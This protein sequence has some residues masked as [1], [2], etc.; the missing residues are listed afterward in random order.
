[1]TTAGC[2]KVTIT[3]TKE[4]QVQPTEPNLFLITTLSCL[5]FGIIYNQY[6]AKVLV[7][8]LQERKYGFGEGTQEGKMV[9]EL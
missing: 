3:A 7:I 6:L 5:C 4:S 9:K 2:Q 1:M 8:L